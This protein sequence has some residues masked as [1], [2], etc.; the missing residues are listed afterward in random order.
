VLLPRLDRNPLG[1]L[2]QHVRL[3][4][5]LVAHAARSRC[6]VRLGQLAAK[7]V[8]E[9]LARAVVEQP[10]DEL[11]RRVVA[12][13]GHLAGAVLYPHGATQQIVAV[14]KLSAVE[15][16]LA[17]QQAARRAQQLVRLALFVVDLE[18]LAFVVVA[19][20]DAVA[21]GVDARAQQASAQLPVHRGLASQPLTQ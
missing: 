3:V 11:A 7:V 13:L 19:Q 2:D 9:R 12:Q 18:E 17:H 4:D 1:D 10:R 5:D 16:V 21:V 6:V 14:T 20:R 8:R 15:G